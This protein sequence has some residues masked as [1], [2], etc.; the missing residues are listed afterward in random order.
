MRGSGGAGVKVGVFPPFVS[1]VFG[2]EGEVFGA[3]GSVKAPR[4]TS[5][6]GT[7]QADGSLITI[8]QMFN[9]IAR[10]PGEIIQ[11]YAGVGGG[12]SA[13]LLKD[14][15]IQSGNIGLTGSSGDV[16]FAHQ[17]LGGVRAYLG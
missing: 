16:T 17:F 10:Y 7:T 15:Y 13:G 4:V 12:W 11:P 8:N 14:V 1:K 5:G 3:G 9:L 2:I 6:T